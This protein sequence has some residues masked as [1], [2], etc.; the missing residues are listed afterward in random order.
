MPENSQ[1]S[2]IDHDIAES[3]DETLINEELVS[4][5]EPGEEE[6]AEE[7]S[8]FTFRPSARYAMYLMVT[9]VVVLLFVVSLVA[10]FDW[11]SLFFLVASLVGM[12]WSGDQLLARVELD[13]TEIRLRQLWR[14]P[15]QVAFRQMNSLEVA[16][17]LFST[18]VFTYHPLQPDGLLDLQDLQT[19]TL[20]AL[21]EQDLLLHLLEARA[22]NLKMGE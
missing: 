3:D 19:L 11:G 21:E 10:R 6:P 13:A 4:G 17:R 14:T 20:P 7:E 18:L 8:V 9:T 5:E 22:T 12:I 15:K 2:Q 1:A 16:G